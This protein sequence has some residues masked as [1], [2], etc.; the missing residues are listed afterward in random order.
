MLNLYTISTKK[1][2]TEN[3][4]TNGE[5]LSVYYH[6][7]F[8]FPLSFQDLVKW[9]ANETLIL[10]NESAIVQKSGYFYIEGT[11]GIIYKRL[12]RE[13]ISAKKLLLA[14]KAA[15]LISIIPTVKMIAVTGSL[16]MQNA[17]PDSDIDLMIVTGNKRLWLTRLITYGVLK[18]AGLAVRKPGSSKEKD[19]LCLNIWLDENDLGW[20][21]ASR[22][23]Y[24]AH[25]IAQ[26][27][28]LVNKN[29]TYEKFLS[30][31]R[32]ILNYWPNSVRISNVEYGTLNRKSKFH[33]Q[34]SIFIPIEKICYWLQKRYM[35]SKITREIA[36]PTRALFHPQDWGKIVIGRLSS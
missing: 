27:I 2:S 5:K 20:K 17:S 26:I 18:M 6:N 11:E 28:P 30:K 4:L 16:A 31:N 7:I 15:W 10:G 22:N 9:R 24:S 8:D 19:A 21:K 34:N 3:Q 25:E 13:R 36:S 1:V 32:W 35:K 29:K 33:I 23:L 12:L 14:K